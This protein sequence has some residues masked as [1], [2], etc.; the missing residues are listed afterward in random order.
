MTLLQQNNLELILI[1]IYCFV[2][3]TIKMLVQSIAFSLQRPGKN[4]PPLKKNTTFPL[5]N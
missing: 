1:M 4:I 3:N 2:D 5:P